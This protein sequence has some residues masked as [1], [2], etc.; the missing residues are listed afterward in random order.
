MKRKWPL[1]I[2][3][4][5]DAGSYTYWDNPSRDMVCSLL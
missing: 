2:R 5:S 3:H 1:A 4:Y